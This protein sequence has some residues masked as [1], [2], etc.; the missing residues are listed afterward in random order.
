[1]ELSKFN[2]LKVDLTSMLPFRKDSF[3]A[4]KPQLNMAVT[5]KQPNLLLATC[6]LFWS[7]DRDLYCKWLMN[8]AVMIE[9]VSANIKSQWT[10]KYELNL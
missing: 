1:M 2:Y 4:F 6:L 10:S 3:F 7:S 8:Y 5:E 9:C